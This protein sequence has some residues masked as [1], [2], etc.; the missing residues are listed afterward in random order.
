MGSAC[1][2][3]DDLL[4]PSMQ[5]RLELKSCYLEILALTKHMLASFI[6]Q[7]WL[8]VAATARIVDT[9]AEILRTAGEVSLEVDLACFEALVPAYGRTGAT[10]SLMDSSA[11][12]DLLG[13]TMVA[14]FASSTSFDLGL[15]S[16]DFIAFASFTACADSTAK[17]AITS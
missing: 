4:V 13:Q 6:L 5:R 2:P 7:F 15:A 16:V 1:S 9:T 11:S 14:C 3:R 8:A 10:I 12:L 17:A